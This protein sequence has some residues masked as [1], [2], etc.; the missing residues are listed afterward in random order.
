MVYNDPLTSLTVQAVCICIFDASSSL[1]FDKW[2]CNYQNYVID[3]LWKAK[4]KMNRN[5]SYFFMASTPPLTTEFFGILTKHQLY[6]W[7]SCK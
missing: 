7:S 1:S 4:K 2:L 5:L 3:F 6:I